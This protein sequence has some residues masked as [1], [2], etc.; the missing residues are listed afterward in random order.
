[1]TDLHA[2]LIDFDGTLADTKN[3][4]YVSYAEALSEHNIQ[5]DFDTFMQF[6]DGKHWSEFLPVIYQYA[7]INNPP[8]AENI[9]K[10]KTEL[11]KTHANKIRFNEPLVTLLKSVSKFSSIALVTTAS[12]ANVQSALAA[13]PDIQTLFSFVIA[14]EDVKQH[15]PHPEAY[16]IA[17][18]RL[19]VSPNQCLIFEDSQAGIASAEAFG[20][21]VIK[22]YI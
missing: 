4:N 22:T 6:S 14:G 1:M 8:L 18:E 11:Y 13:R 5:I 7:K 2:Y 15:K 21:Q 16:Q 19:N 17:A 9:A 3:A 10:R 20:G 12:T